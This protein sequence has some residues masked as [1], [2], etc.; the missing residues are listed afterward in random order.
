MS[1]T[2]IVSY[3]FCYEAGLDGLVGR[4]RIF[5]RIH[6]A[7]RQAAVKAIR[8]VSED[9]MV[10]IKAPVSSAVAIAKLPAPAA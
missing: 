10:V 9:R 8:G 6:A 5:Q 1:V 3:R 2:L 7:M 4:C